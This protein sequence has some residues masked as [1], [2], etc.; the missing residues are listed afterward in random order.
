MHIHLDLIG[1]IAGDMFSAAMLDAHP[2]L[3]QP[4][5]GMLNSLELDDQV[6]VSLE[7]G[8]DKGLNGKRFNV[9]LIAPLHPHHHSHSHEQEHSDEQKYRHEHGHSHDHHHHHDWQ[10]I[11]RYLTNS[12]LEHCVKE[13]AIGI[14]SLL[15]TAEAKVHNMDI[16]HVQFHEVGAWD[17]IVDIISAAWLIHHSHAT[18]WSVSGLPWGGGTVKCAHGVIPVP[19]PATLNLL[20]GFHFVDDG[21]L[22]ERITPTG[23]A[24]LAW[25]SPE[26]KVA[27]GQLQG[28]GYG[29]GTKRLSQRANVIRASLLEPSPEQQKEQIAIVQCDI[30]DMTGE[31]I[32]NARESLR[33]HPGVL[34]ITESVSHGKKHRMISTLTLLCQPYHLDDIVTAILNQTSTLGVR[35]WLCDRVSLPRLHH[36]ISHNGKA[37]NVKTV[38]RPDGSQT[39]K[40]EADHLEDA[41]P[42]YHQKQQLKHTIEHHVQEVEL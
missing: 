3:E 31:M 18:S 40:L 26:Q 14:F 20:T 41:G 35:H 32:A 19:A 30:D 5:L 16:E 11:R 36:Q 22:G 24:I 39:T 25:L 8:E 27:K 7:H 17:C 6:I 28:T 9:D 1:G 2:H 42:S 12:S 21:E 34:E 10:Q 23:A 4:L 38:K 15:A 13:H 29:F 37:F 33:Q